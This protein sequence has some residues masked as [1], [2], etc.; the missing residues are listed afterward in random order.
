MAALINPFHGRINRLQWWMYQF[1]IF[2]LTAV[3]FV[4]IALYFVDSHGPEFKWLDNEIAAL[5]LL[6]L[7][8][9]IMNFSTCINR[10][11]DTGRSG[12]WYLAFL[13]PTFG[14]ALMIYFCGI[15][16]GKKDPVVSTTV[17]PNLRMIT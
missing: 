13:G 15:E 5:V 11:R 9:S 4:G 14:T 16:P 8:S 3:G 10:L 12:F 2:F 1:L 7:L 6:V 17:Q